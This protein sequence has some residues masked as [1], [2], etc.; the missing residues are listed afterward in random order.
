MALVSWAL[1]SALEAAYDDAEGRQMLA[2]F[3]AAAGGV[4]TYSGVRP[5]GA[6]ADGFGVVANGTPNN[7]VTVNT[8]VLHSQSGAGEYLTVNNASAVLTVP[9]ADASLLRK[10]AVMVDPAQVAASRLIYVAGTPG[11]ASYPA[12]TG[13]QYKLA[14]VDCRSVAV[15]LGTVIRPADIFDQRTYTACF[16]G[17]IL[18]TSS[19]RPATPP[20]GQEIFETD[21]GLIYTYDGTVWA[22]TNLVQMVTSATRPATP[23]A[24]HQIFETDTGLVRTWRSDQSKWQMVGGDNP[25]AIFTITGNK[26]HSNNAWLTIPWDTT[27]INDPGGATQPTAGSMSFIT[28]GQSTRVWIPITGWYRVTWGV[29]ESAAGTSDGINE[30]QIRKNAAGNIASGTQLVGTNTRPNTQS[31]ASYSNNTRTISLTAGDYIELFA[32]QINAGSNNRNVQNA[33]NN[34]Y[35]EIVFIRDA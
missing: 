28:T 21:T 24:G 25:M 18:C 1:N 34:T 7:T 12:A 4:T 26:F 33:N 20:L 27:S 11:G 31:G 3:M 16:G 9:A 19:T 35:L 15:A 32:Y 30:T 2:G 14:N 17:R 10:D 13:T 23:K 8:G 29:D 5:S 22:R 6:T